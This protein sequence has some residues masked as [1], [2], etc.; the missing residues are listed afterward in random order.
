MDLESRGW[1]KSIEVSGSSEF[2]TSEV[3]TY[4][5]GLGAD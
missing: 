5:E 3:P 2:T 1:H 4:C